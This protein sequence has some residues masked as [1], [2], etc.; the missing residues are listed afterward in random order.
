MKDGLF[1][2]QKKYIE[3]LLEKCGFG[4]ARSLP[5]PMV[6]SCNLSANDGSPIQQ[7]TEYQSIVGAIQYIIIT[8]P[9]IAYAVNQICQFM[10][11]PLYLQFNAVKRILRY[12]Q[13][14]SDYGLKFPNNS[15]LSITGFADANWAQILMIDDPLLSI[16]SISEVIL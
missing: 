7:V 13:G 1:L 2:N 6:S 11:S 15:H 12:L 3:D 8:Q 10:Q 4:N 14:T 5:T 16:A 9:E